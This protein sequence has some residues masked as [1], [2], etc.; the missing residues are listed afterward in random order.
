MFHALEEEFFGPRRDSEQ[1]VLKLHSERSECWLQCWTN[2]E[3]WKECPTLRDAF[4]QPFRNFLSQSQRSFLSAQTLPNTQHSIFL[5]HHILVSMFP[6]WSRMLRQS[7][8][9]VKWDYIR[10]NYSVWFSPLSP[11]YLIECY[12]EFDF[13]RNV[14]PLSFLCRMLFIIKYFL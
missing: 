7:R 5:T 2:Y 8:E 4:I 1:R 12:S 13:P 11:V 6:H 10:N 14:H 3:R 9:M